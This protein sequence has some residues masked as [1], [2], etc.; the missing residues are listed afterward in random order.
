M[1]AT[2]QR[3]SLPEMPAATDRKEINLLRGVPNRT[4]KAEMPAVFES[5]KGTDPGAQLL[6]RFH[7]QRETTAEFVTGCEA[8][9]RLYGNEHFVFKMLNGEQWL[10]LVALHAERHAA[11]IA[12]IKQAPDFL[13]IAG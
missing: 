7:A 8:D 3:G 12:E 11:Q 6:Q 13:E 1:P 2:C 10:L 5:P 4:R 9:L